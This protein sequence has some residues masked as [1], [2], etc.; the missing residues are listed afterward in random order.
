MILLRYLLSFMV[1]VSMLQSTAWG[2]TFSQP[3]NTLQRFLEANPSQRPLMEQ[4]TV[5]VH[6]QPIP[7]TATYP[8]TQKIAVLLRGDEHEVVNRAWQVAFKRRMQ[9]LNVD[10]RLDYFHLATSAGVR[11]VTEVFN[12]IEASNFNYL[13]ID[14][15]DAYNRPLIERIL[16]AGTT[17]V[18]IL[19]VSAPFYQWQLHP[20]MIYIGLDVVKTIHQIASIVGRTLTGDAIVDAILTQDPYL[21]ESRCQLFLD[22]MRLLGLP[23]RKRFIISDDSAEAYRV[24]EDLLIQEKH[25]VPTGHFIFACTPNL[26]KGVA[27]ALMTH[28][29]TP[30]VTTNAWLGQRGLE[31]AHQAGAF[32]VTAFDMKD[33]MAIAAAESIKADM[34]ARLLPLVYTEVAQLLISGMDS[35]TRDIMFQQATRY[36][37]FLWPR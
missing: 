7:L 32:M 29:V 33:N 14:G 5:R 17:R 36:S 27:L 3:A 13:I 15:L 20:P 31:K 35:Q 22:E 10:F 23:V 21:K 28:Q 8:D 2:F 34:E 16:L 9:E 11:P 4:L 25:H 18:I 24:T 6:S 19:N 26:S 1:V 37:S 30:Y 12:K